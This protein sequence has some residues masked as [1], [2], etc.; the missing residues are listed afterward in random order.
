MIHFLV[1]A[2][3]SYLAT[4]PTIFLAKKYRIITDKATRKHPA[5]T[6]TGLIPRAGGVP[7][8]VA[9]LICTIVFIP[10]SK[11]LI[12]ILIAGFMLVILGLLDDKY[13][14]SPYSRLVVNFLVAMIAISGGL[15]IPYIS[16]PFGEPI[17]LAQPQ[18]VFDFFGTHTIWILADLLAVLWLVSLMNITNWSKGVDGQLPGF[19]AVACIF[20]SLAT[21]KFSPYSIDASHTRTLAMIAAG[22]FVGFLP[23]NFYPQKIMPGYGGGA[24][25]GFIL[26]ILAILTFVKAGSLLLLLSIPI[27]DGVCIVTRRIADGQNPF[28]G[29]ANHLHHLLLRRGWSRQFIAIFY[30]VFTTLCGTLSLTLPN[31]ITKL[32][33]ITSVYLILFVWIYRLSVDDRCRKDV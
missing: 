13:D 27:L 29:D 9:F 30:I 8:F 19:V 28:K 31:T 1:A 11:A 32:I 5:H 2:A 4:I 16:N 23:W 6:H 3:L 18:I 22:A 21:R 20:L 7:V 26:G 10:I 12:F 33:V 14:L 24:F 15:G 25:A 17:Q